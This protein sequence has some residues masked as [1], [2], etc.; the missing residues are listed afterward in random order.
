MVDVDEYL[1]RGVM[2]M[3]KCTGKEVEDI[4]SVYQGE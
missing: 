4:G 1:R 2:D 3:V